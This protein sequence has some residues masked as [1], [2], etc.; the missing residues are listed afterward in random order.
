MAVSARQLCSSPTCLL[1]PQTGVTKTRRA[2]GEPTGSCPHLPGIGLCP[3]PM[4]SPSPPSLDTCFIFLHLMEVKT[5]WH[6]TDRSKSSFSLKTQGQEQVQPRVGLL[7]KPVHSVTRRSC[8]SVLRRT[9]H[10]CFWN[11][12]VTTSKIANTG[13][14]LAMYQSSEDK[15]GL[16]CYRHKGLWRQL[17][18]S[19][20]FHL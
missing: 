13:V 20:Q 6:C 12:K 8:H 5:K 4:Q 18:F 3:H 17:L 9:Y 19:A 15:Q 2:K 16:A 10:R 1:N 11:T 14:P 7:S